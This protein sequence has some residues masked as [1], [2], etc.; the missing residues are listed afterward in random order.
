MNDKR[1]YFN[2]EVAINPRGKVTF[3]KTDTYASYLNIYTDIY[4]NPTHASLK[5]LRGLFPSPP[6]LETGS[7]GFEYLVFERKTPKGDIIELWDAL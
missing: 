5:R 7:D 6:I 4:E 3:T 2:I 1:I